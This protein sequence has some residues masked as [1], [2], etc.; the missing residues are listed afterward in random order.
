MVLSSSTGSERVLAPP[1]LHPVEPYQ[2]SNGWVGYGK[3]DDFGKAQ[4]WRAGASGVDAQLTMLGESST[5]EAVGEDGSVLF[6]NQGG[7]YL[8]KVGETPKRINGGFGT[9]IWRDA[10]FLLLIG[11]TV[12]APVP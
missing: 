1:G 8:A 6:R 11:N 7:R 12:F 2:L 5:V 3:R 4:V 10:R 9:P